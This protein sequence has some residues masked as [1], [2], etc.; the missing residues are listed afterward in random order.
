[1]WVKCEH[2]QSKK[3]E[4]ATKKGGRKETVGTKIERR[5]KYG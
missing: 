1:M 2:E 5:T 3:E 4:A